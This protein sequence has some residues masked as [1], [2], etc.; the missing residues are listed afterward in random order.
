MKLVS[1]K[2]TE[3]ASGICVQKTDKTIEINVDAIIYI[4]KEYYIWQ[5]RDVTE[6]F[7]R[8]H[9]SD[10]SFVLISEEEKKNLVQSFS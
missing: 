10:G 7:Y 5:D 4:K 8:V 9:F 3:R 6:A 1:V 2:L